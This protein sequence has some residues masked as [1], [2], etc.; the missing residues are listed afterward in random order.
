MDSSG[1]TYD[2]SIVCTSVSNQKTITNEFTIKFED[3]EITT[4]KGESSKQM[5]L[6]RGSSSHDLDYFVGETAESKLSFNIN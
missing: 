5:V 1:V 4:C 3:E 2:D 6:G